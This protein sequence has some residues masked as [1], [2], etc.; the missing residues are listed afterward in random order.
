[1]KLED[2]LAAWDVDS[3]INRAEL[4]GELQKLSK[5]H[6]KYYTMLVA[7]RLQLLKVQTDL[8]RL[9]QEKYEFFTTGATAETVEKGW[10]L[11]PRGVLLKADAGQY[12]DTDNDVINMTLK[13]GVQ[14]EKVDLLLSILNELKGR[15]WNVRGMIEWEKLKNGM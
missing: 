12:I 3:N 15:S 1:M 5:L 8:K 13:V 9:R 6:H 7:E 14:N 11:P 10:K 2:I 4:G